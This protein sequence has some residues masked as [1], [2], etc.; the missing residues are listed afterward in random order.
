MAYSFGDLELVARQA[1][2]SPE[3][4]PVMGGYWAR[5]VRVAT[6]ERIIQMPALVIT[7]MV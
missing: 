5:R 1:G 7:L 4:A 2:F 6:L 3:L